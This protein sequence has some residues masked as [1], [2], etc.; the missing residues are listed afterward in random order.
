MQQPPSGTKP[1][2]VSRPSLAELHA[3]GKSLRE[4]CPRHSHA[5]WKA[6]D[7]RPDPLRLL[8]QSNKGR[9]PELIPIRHGRMVRTP[10]TFYRGVAL[11]MA[12]DL[13]RTPVTGLRVQA[14]GDCHLLNFGAYATPERRLL[15]DINDLDETLPAP[16]EWDVKR[17]AASVVLACRNNGFSKGN[18][19]DAVLA[20]VRSYREHMAEYS[21]MPV[22]Q[23]WYASIDVEKMVAR[24]K[25]KEAGR[26]VLKR[27]AAARAR[28]VLEHDFPSS[29][30]APVERPPSRTIHP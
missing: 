9:I 22:L 1:V 24:V 29:Q 10:F 30:P 20:C 25:D 19:R 11:N 4:K 13:A 3:I 18:A 12:A 14:C 6:P 8:E 21:D 7:N 17:L 27:I 26:R 2:A 16:S 15:F 28:N 5:D 23:V